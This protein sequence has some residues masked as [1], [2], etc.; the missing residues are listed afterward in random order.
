[1]SEESS[2]RVTSADGLRGLLAAFVMFAHLMNAAGDGRFLGLAHLSVMSFFAIS[3]Y[4]LTR[5]WRGRYLGFLVRRV[6]RLWPVYALCMAVGGWLSMNPA[7]ASLFFW[8]PFTSV[9]AQ[10]PQD[11]PAWS[12]FVEV[13]AMPLMPAII[14]IGRRPLLVLPAAAACVAAKWVQPDLLYGAFF[15]VGSYLAEK[16]TSSAFLD[17]RPVQWLGRISYSLYLSHILVF[18]ALKFNLPGLWFYLCIPSALLVAQA[19]SIAVERPSILL[20]RMA[21]RLVERA[22]APRATLTP[23]G[24]S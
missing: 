8:F 24:A 3:G 7:R 23:A 21:G 16:T 17:S 13:W 18:G 4:V 6:V 9:S 1:M 2:A 12:L 10:L 20:S 22:L 11:P 14:W 15:I 5:G 19:L